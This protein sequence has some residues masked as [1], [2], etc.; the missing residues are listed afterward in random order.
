MKCLLLTGFILAGFAP[1]PT[2]AEESFT[3]RDFAAKKQVFGIK[4]PWEMT[5]PYADSY[6]DGAPFPHVMGNIAP[7]RK[8]LLLR[9]SEHW[10]ASS[11]NENIVVLITLDKDGKLLAVDVLES[12]GK[13]RFDEKALAAIKT[14]IFPRLPDWYKG[15]QLVFKID[16]AK[17]AALKQ[18]P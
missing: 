8:D 17:V 9:I 6:P 12:S 10:T 1:Q 13:K 5:T 7:Y 14:T 2:L 15:S 3:E 11:A 16:M 4:Y 18:H